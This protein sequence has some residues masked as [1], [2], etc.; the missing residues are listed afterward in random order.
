MSFA[1]WSAKQ[2]FHVSDA[3]HTLAGMAYGGSLKL[4]GVYPLFSS[5]EYYSFCP[6]NPIFCSISALLFLSK[7]ICWILCSF[8][9]DEDR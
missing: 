8:I 6:P 5:R 4:C 1:L 2:H 3:C 7:D 9:Y